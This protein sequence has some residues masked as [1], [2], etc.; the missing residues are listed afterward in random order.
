VGSSG[1]ASGEPD[2]GVTA[3]S[4]L[5]VRFVVAVVMVPSVLAAWARTVN[6]PPRCCASALSLGKRVVNVP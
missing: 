2:A 4:S 6:V 5:T 3:P 1:V